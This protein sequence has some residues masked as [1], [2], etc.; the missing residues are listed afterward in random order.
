M[1]LL[2]ENMAASLSNIKMGKVFLTK[3]QN[4][5]TINEEFDQFNCLKIKTSWWRK[6]TQNKV[7]R[8]EG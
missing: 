8:S 4:A 2:E 7:R 1:K 6:L 3:T 5:E